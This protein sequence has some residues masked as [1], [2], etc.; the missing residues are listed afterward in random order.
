MTT[1]PSPFAIPT[2]RI[3]HDPDPQKRRHQPFQP[4]VFRWQCLT[5]PPTSYN[6]PHNPPHPSWIGY[7]DAQ[8]VADTLF[9]RCKGMLRLMHNFM[10]AWE[11]TADPD[12]EILLDRADVAS[13]RENLAVIGESLD[14]ALAAMREVRS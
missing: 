3:S 9:S 10:S 1:A 13:L 2:S 14:I 4:E 7:T 8:G 12:A 5:A 11:D 6:D